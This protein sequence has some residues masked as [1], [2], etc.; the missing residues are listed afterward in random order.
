MALGLA[1]ALLVILPSTAE[2]GECG[3]GETCLSDDSSSNGTPAVHSDPTVYA[4]LVTARRS[5]AVYANGTGMGSHCVRLG[6]GTSQ[7]LRERFGGQRLQ[8]CRYSAVPPGIETPPPGVRGAARYLLRSCLGNIDFDTYA[9]G[10]DRTLDASVAW[11][12]RGTDTSDRHDPLSDFLWDRTSAGAQLP[13]PVVQPRPIPV[14]VVGAPT[15]FTFRWIDPGSHQVVGPVR[16]VE[17]DG[18]LLRAEATQVVVDPQQR[19]LGAVRCGPLTSAPGTCT[20]VFGR[21]SA[22]ARDQATEPIPADVTDAF[23]LRVE[24]EWR[25][26]YGEVASTS[27][28]LGDGFTMRLRQAL[29]VQEV[30]APNLPPS[31]VW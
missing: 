11:V 16:T 21:S 9:G 31:I 24:V 13:V 26:T 18:L 30:Q 20:V 1:L 5:C 27:R 22:S 28:E 7:T 14:P 15:T 17:S 12:P 2:A 4:P 8:R 29:P 3:W 25:I 6:G 19:D 23:H 10:K